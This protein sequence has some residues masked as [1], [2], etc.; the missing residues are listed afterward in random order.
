MVY[1]DFVKWSKNFF[2]LVEM[3]KLCDEMEDSQFY[4]K[5][6]QAS[7]WKL[8]EEKVLSMD[9]EGNYS[10]RP[11]LFPGF[12]LNPELK[13]GRNG[14]PRSPETL[15]FTS[16][17]IA[18]R[19]AKQVARVHRIRGKEGVRRCFE[20][21]ENLGFEIP[22][23]IDSDQWRILRFKHWDRPEYDNG[24]DIPVELVE[25]G[26]LTPSKKAWSVFY[27]PYGCDSPTDQKSLNFIGNG[28]IF[29]FKDQGDAE[30]YARSFPD[31]VREKIRAW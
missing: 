7:F 30:E 3:K 19:F 12:V 21:I 22:E 26:F 1:E 27:R 2:P 18:W 15:Y 6:E 8:L 17:K 10:V 31:S 20:V 4:P 14:D 13:Q 25:R 24:V 5:P 9:K 16:Y 29:Y 11:V 23:E 28:K